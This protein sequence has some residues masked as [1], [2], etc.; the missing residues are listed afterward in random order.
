MDVFDPSCAGNLFDEVKLHSNLCQEKPAS[1][2]SHPLYHISSSDL[3]EVIQR[4]LFKQK[5][6]KKIIFTH[7]NK[8][9]FFLMSCHNSEHLVNASC[10][11]LIYHVLTS[12]AK[13]DNP[14]WV[15]T[16]DDIISVFCNC[17]APKEMLMSCSSPL[18][19]RVLTPPIEGPL[20][21]LRITNIPWVLKVIT[22]ILVHHK[23]DCYSISE[24]EHLLCI[25]L[26]VSLDKHVMQMKSV[27][28]N[29]EFSKCIKSILAAY[30]SCEWRKPGKVSRLSKMLYCKLKNVCISDINCIISNYITCPGL[31]QKLALSLSYSFIKGMVMSDKD[32]KHLD[33]IEVKD[34]VKIFKVDSLLEMDY[35]TQ[36]YLLLLVER[37]IT[38]LIFT[39]GNVRHLNNIRQLLSNLRIKPAHS[40]EMIDYLLVKELITRATTTWKLSI[41]ELA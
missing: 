9:L 35:C 13:T 17:G 32:L 36:Y 38:N 18:P 3:Y 29:I 24:L 41:A 16:I 23:K 7:I 27:I 19:P 25:I 10:D 39:S 33:N 6:K 5:M 2:M 15:P 37:V 1:M 14:P 31:G 28:I 12:A 8:Y 21:D 34:I 4:G 30:P 11:T 22:A 20:P 26:T 40:E